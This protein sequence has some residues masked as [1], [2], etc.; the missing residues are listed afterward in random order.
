V[1]GEVFDVAVDVRR[2]S[3]TFGAWAGEILSANNR[4]IMFIPEGFAHGFCVLSD[5]AAV[6]YKTSDVYAPQEERGIR[7]DSPEVGIAWPIR[8][9]AILSE[10]D[11]LLPR[12][13]EVGESDFPA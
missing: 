2:G 8:E 7:W 5:S 1:S 9:T 13:S 12:L 11:A 10:R 3:A 6:L 4:R